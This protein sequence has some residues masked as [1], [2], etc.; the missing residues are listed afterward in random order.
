MPYRRLPNTDSSRLRSLK[1]A[2]EKGRELPP[3]KKPYSS[4]SLQNINTVLNKYEMFIKLHKEAYKIQVDKSP[5]YNLLY[6]KA[7]NYVSHFLQVLNLAIIRGDLKVEARGFFNIKN[8]KKLPA[9]KTENDVIKWGKIVLE[10]E[11]NRIGNGGNPMTNPTVGIVRVHYD[12]FIE[13]HRHQKILQ[14]NT[15]RASEKISTIRKE[16]DKV[17]LQ[18]WNEIEES[19]ST[20]T[21]VER[22]NLCR[23]FGVNYFF[24]RNEV[25]PEDENVSI[26]YRQKRIVNKDIKKTVVEEQPLEPDSSDDKEELS[27]DNI[28]YS[29]F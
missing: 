15:S 20:G 24:R 27:L 3:H 5:T 13:A 22:R 14:E 28:Q 11:Q 26:E 21:E 25:I 6:K 4:S 12:K 2:F 17:I 29:L 10:G 16:V 18:L 8:E 23:E 9:F 7:K 19:F 1:I